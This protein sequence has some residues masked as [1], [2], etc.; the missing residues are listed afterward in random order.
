MRSLD[1]Y[2]KSEL[3]IR[4][5]K[6]KDLSEWKRIFAMI[7]YD[8]GQSIEELADLLRLSTYTV[9]LSVRSLDEYEKSELEIRLKKSKDLSEWKRIFAMIG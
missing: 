5:K 6:S 1:E 4:L 8:D 7:G 2:Q 9:E 3:E